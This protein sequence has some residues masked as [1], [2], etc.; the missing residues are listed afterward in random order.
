MIALTPNKKRESK[1]NGNFIVFDIESNNWKNFVLSGIYDGKIF[2]T[3]T[4]LEQLFFQLLSY[5]KTTVFS[6]FGGI[7]DHLFLF[8]ISVRLGTFPTDIIMRGSSIFSFT[9]GYTRFIDSSGILPFSLSHAAK[10][11]KVQHQKLDIDHSIKKRASDKKLIEYL[12][13]DCKA[14]FETIKKF[15]ESELFTD[16]SERATL[17]GLSIEKLRNY[18]TR[19]IKSLSPAMD[20]VVRSAYA[21]GR[22]EI[23]RPYYNNKENPIYYYDFNSLYPSVM[24][25]LEICGGFKKPTRKINPQSFLQIEAEVKK[26]IYLPILWQ[27]QKGKFLFPVGKIKG[28]FSGIEIQEAIEQNQL[29]NLKIIKGYQ[30]ENLGRQLAPFITEL[31]EIRKNATDPVNNT[32]AKLLLNSCYGRFAINRERENIVFDEGQ[33]GITPINVTIAGRRLAKIKSIYK[34]FSN[35]A[36]GAQITAAARIKLQKEMIPIQDQIYYCDTDSIFTTAIL[37]TSK[38]L[39]DLKSEDSDNKA[40]FL[41]PKGYFF[42]QAKLKGFPKEFMQAKSF[43]DFEQALEGDLKAFRSSIP[44]RL[45]K[46]K[47]ARHENSALKLLAGNTRQLRAKYDKRILLKISEKFWDSKPVE[48]Q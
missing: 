40:C 35:V 23:F 12:E 39:G 17:A 26:D 47:S 13:H 11:F 25:N 14:L 6:H 42:K 1:Q 33:I 37:P 8:D 27:K 34:G 7:F 32:I 48:F 43:E 46:I 9:I 18:I 28:L 41:L 3:Q 45:A 21:G 30:F 44:A 2:C 38:N 20:S 31:Y 19:P 36:I 10:A 24:Q 29:K 16:V 4:S 15:K 22:V 5:G